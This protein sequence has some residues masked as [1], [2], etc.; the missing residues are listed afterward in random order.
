MVQD[1]VSHSNEKYPLAKILFWTRTLTKTSPYLNFMRKLPLTPDNLFLDLKHEICFDLSI[2]I[3][4]TPDIPSF[5]QDDFFFQILPLWDLVVKWLRMSPTHIKAY[6]D[7]CLWHF[8]HL[9]FSPTTEFEVIY[10]IYEWSSKVKLGALFLPGE[11]KNNKVWFSDVEIQKGTF[12]LFWN[13]LR[14]RSLLSISLKP[15]D[16]NFQMWFILLI[17]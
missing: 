6:G 7:L 4:F 5:T 13:Q 11:T 3:S 10:P 9:K 17:F 8:R 1:S 2:L 14:K 16:Q 12:R 15:L